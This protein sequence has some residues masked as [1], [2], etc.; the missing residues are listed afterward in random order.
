M[1]KHTNRNNC[2]R[3]WIYILEEANQSLLATI[4]TLSHP[5]YKTKLLCNPPTKTCLS[6]SRVTFSFL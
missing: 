1:N 5:K 2:F 3:I 6:I 4:P